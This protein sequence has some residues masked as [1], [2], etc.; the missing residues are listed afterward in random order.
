M[1]RKLIGRFICWLKGRHIRGRL[2]SKDET[3]KT[4]ECERCGRRT[5]YSIKSKA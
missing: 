1:L 3:H 5:I 4:F 2:V